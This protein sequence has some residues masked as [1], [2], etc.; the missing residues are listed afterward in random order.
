MT[1][2][3]YELWKK[4]PANGD[5]E[6][7][8]LH[9]SPAVRKTDAAV[10][11]VPGSG[12]R[13]NPSKPQQEGDR[14]ARYL[15]DE[16]IEVFMLVYRVGDGCYPAPI[17]DARRAMRMVRYKAKDFGIDPH[18]IIPLGYSAGGHLC[19][20]LVGFLDPVEGEGADE[21]DKEDFVP[22]YQA[23]CYPVISFDVTKSYTHK[24]S[25]SSL[26][27]EDYVD[28][29]DAMSFETAQ[30]K[31]VPPTFLFHNFDD[32][33]VGVEN[34]LLYACKLRELGTSVEMHVYPDGGHGVGLAIDDSRSSLHNKDWLVRFVEWLKYNDLLG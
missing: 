10:L 1:P 22:D 27:G 3:R 34:T 11:L 15:T 14:V 17:L 32:K 9:Y 2:V 28:L 23:L 25:V 33:C 18:K 8:I 31:K 6:P 29:A 20:S 26:L 30:D 24:G 12:Y 16:G 13:A 7:Y 5:Y 19:A 21:M 4:A